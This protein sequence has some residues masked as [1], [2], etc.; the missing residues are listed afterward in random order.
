LLAKDLPALNDSFKAKGQQPV[1][2][3]P[4]KVGATDAT[5][6]PGGAAAI[7]GF[8]SSDFRLCQ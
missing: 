5:R 3:P 8:L 6:D 7:T 2:A 4:A 1:P